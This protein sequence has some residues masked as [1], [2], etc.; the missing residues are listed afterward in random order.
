M[1]QLAPLQLK[2]TLYS[3]PD[4]WSSRIQHPSGTDQIASITNPLILSQGIPSPPARLQ[5]QVPVASRISVSPMG[6]DPSVSKVIVQE[7]KQKL[8]KLP[9]NAARLILKKRKRD[10]ASPLLRP[11]HWLPVERKLQYK[12]ATIC[13]KCVHGTAPQYLQN[14][15]KAYVPKRQLRSATDP[16]ALVVPRMRLKT[17]GEKSFGYCAPR[18]WNA[19]PQGLP[20]AGSVDT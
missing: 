10:H 15:V 6:V 18:V 2:T 1:F 13:Y 16:T 9:S 14:L 20:E 5:Y 8:Q 19:L 12:A 17:V 4:V 11:L 7:N 3:G